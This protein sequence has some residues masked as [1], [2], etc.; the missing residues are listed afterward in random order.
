MSK[1]LGHTRYNPKLISHYLPK[2][3]QTFFQERWVRIFQRS[4]ICESLKDSQYFLEATSFQS[5]E[6]LDRFLN[7]YALKDI[8][9][10]LQDPENKKDNLRDS[11][12]LF[13]SVD[14]NILTILISLQ[15]AV[16]QALKPER[17]VDKALYWCRFCALLTKKIEDGYDMQLKD[18]LYK[19]RKRVDPRQ[20]GKLIY[21]L[22]S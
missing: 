4:L 5:I 14:V 19:A 2:E 15:K 1:A 11:D 9:N 10:H 8:P 20:I 17:V 13:I 7:N 12:K 6:E 18:H 16:E 21:G 3:I 22:S